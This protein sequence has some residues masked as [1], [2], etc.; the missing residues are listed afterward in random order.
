MTVKEFQAAGLHKLTASELQVLNQWIT[1]LT[2]LAQQ[3]A[4]EADQAV[5]GTAIPGTYPV[6]DPLMMRSSL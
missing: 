5:S 2:A 3:Q 4:S 6:E 1:R